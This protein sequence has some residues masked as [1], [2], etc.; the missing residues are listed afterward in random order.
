MTGFEPEKEGRSHQ[1][2]KSDRMRR[3]IVLSAIS[4]LYEYGYHRTSIKKIAQASAFSQGAMQH[5]FPSKEDLMVFV[6]QK[7]LTKSVR[8]TL[9]WAE[10]VGQEN[11]RISDLTKEWWTNQMRSP[12]FLAM[13]EIMVGARTDDSLRS[14]LQPVV[15]EY[16]EK[17]EDYILALFPESRYG[18]SVARMM[19]IASRSMLCG[20][21]THDA[22][23]RSEQELDQFVNEWAE[24]LD[25]LLEPRINTS[26]IN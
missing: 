14:R 10:E 11:V 25:T 20:L 8:L 1:Q 22:M 21:V 13:L 26:S 4:C 17:A 24:V 12:E 15:T 16:I 2:Q 18:P 23:F 9:E 19:V 3:D 6:M 5:H 7:I